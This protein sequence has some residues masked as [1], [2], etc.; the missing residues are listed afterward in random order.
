MSASE[1]PIAGY[2]KLGSGGVAGG[3]VAYILTLDGLSDAV[4][5][6]ALAAVVLT[7]AAY[8]WGNARE[9]TASADRAWAESPNIAPDPVDA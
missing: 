3:A 5:V 4:M 8:V 2:R 9:H 7:Y 1:S 6:A